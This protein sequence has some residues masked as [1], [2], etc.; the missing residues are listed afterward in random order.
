MKAPLI[1]ALVV[2]LAP[3]QA[4]AWGSMGHRIVG[5]SAMQ[6]LPD[7]IPAFLRN[8]TAVRDVGELSR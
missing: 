4:L 2:A 7:E 8:P 6:A 1:A 5:E 3:A